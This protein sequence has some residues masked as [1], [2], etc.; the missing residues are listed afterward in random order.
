ME[1]YL[2]FG[3]NLV[4]F[5]QH[6][7][8]WG[9]QGGHAFHLNYFRRLVF[10]IQSLAHPK[11]MAEL[12]N[13]FMKN[14]LR[15]D[16]V[17]ANTCILEQAVRQWFYYNS[18]MQ[19]RVALLN[20]SFQFFQ[21]KFSKEA[22]QHIY[23][24]DGILL[25]SQEY[26]NETLS[27]ILQFSRCHRKEGLMTVKLNMGGNRI[28]LVTFWVASDTN[29]KM[30]LWIGALQG[31]QGEVQTIR[32]LTKHFFGYRPKALMIYVL[33][34]IAQQLQLE[35]I[36]A[37]SNEGFQAS[38]HISSKRRLKTSLDDFWKTIGGEVCS[39]SRFFTLPLIEL[40][41]DLGE[42]ASHKR[43]LYRKRFTMLDAIDA[44]ITKALESYLSRNS[45]V[46]CTTF[47]GQYNFVC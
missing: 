16:I 36:Y 27:L 25:W 5:I 17:Y 20:T 18:T 37:V 10:V 28:Y 8:A 12:L 15:R 19:E 46:R 38:H 35:L 24:G 2:Q 21:D 42:V 4:F 26:K 45:Y 33:R 41:K 44:E 9:G 13:F 39:D 40:R 14:S 23:L 6:R 30:A 31:S 29:G 34:I 43:N 32:N 22:L 11:Q 1:K 47:D 3:H 7:S